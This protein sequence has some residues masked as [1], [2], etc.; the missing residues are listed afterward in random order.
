MTTREQFQSL[1]P[2]APLPWEEHPHRKGLILDANG[3][4][5]C[6]VDGSD[7]NWRGIAAMIIVA[8]NTC[9]GFKAELRGDA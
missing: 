8:V 6:W 2:D 7:P 4:D 3:E 1:A 5:V 9:A